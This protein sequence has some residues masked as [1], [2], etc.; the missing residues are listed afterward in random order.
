MFLVEGGEG[1]SCLSD[2]RSRIHQLTH[3]PVEQGVM[4]VIQGAWHLLE[5]G[6]WLATVNLQSTLMPALSADCK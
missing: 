5:Q 6:G 4:G 3:C 2:E 1:G